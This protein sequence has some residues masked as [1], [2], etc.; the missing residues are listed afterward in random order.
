MIA[1]LLLWLIAVV[2]IP[3]VALLLFLAKRKG[4]LRQFAI[5]SVLFIAAMIC[6]GFLGESPAY[7]S[8]RDTIHAVG[9]GR[10]QIFADGDAAYV[11]IDD[12]SNSLANNAIMG[13]L[14]WAEAKD[15]YCL[16]TSEGHFHFVD[17]RTGKGTT[18]LK[19]NDIPPSHKETF[20]IMRF[21][22]PYGQLWEDA[23]HLHWKWF[24]LAG[25]LF[26]WGIRI[27]MLIVTNKRKDLCNEN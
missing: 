8:G 22:G 17:S 7:H 13:V 20:R 1:L 3:P 12:A 14:K 26:V 11:F 16:I 4:K 9:N 5:E 6:L 10:F 15:G 18:Y 23:S 24:A 21:W 27:V 19:F 2:A 25:L